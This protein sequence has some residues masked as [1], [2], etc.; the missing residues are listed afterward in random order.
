VFI[1]DSCNPHVEDRSGPIESES[2]A[3]SLKR[4]LLVQSRALR[5][6]IGNWQPI[7]DGFVTSN[8]NGVSV[9]FAPG[10]GGWQPP[11]GAVGHSGR[12]Y[13][14][15]PP[16]HLDDFVEA[17]TNLTWAEDGIGGPACDANWVRFKG[18]VQNILNKF[19][20]AHKDEG[21]PGGDLDMLRQD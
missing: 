16:V 4:D 7:V 18:T 5:W 2:R 1:C 13:Y 9:N 3:L 17:P 21:S 10:S 11:F 14:F 6:V 12:K 15:I 19:L 20:D 8:R